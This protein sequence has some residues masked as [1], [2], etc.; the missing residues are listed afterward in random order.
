M[1]MVV[2]IMNFLDVL[3]S[4]DGL[5]QKLE[6]L[7]FV[8]GQRLVCHFN[9]GFVNGEWAPILVAIL[10][11][12]SNKLTTAALQVLG[13]TVVQISGF[14]YQVLYSPDLVTT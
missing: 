1:T 10:E 11:T 3:L 7:N 2:I 8:I 6:R 5:V 13:I 12:P 14:A 9:S 4:F